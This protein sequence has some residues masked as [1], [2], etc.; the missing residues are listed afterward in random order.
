M[1][2][3]KHAVCQ[4]QIDNTAEVSLDTNDTLAEIPY[5]SLKYIY[6]Q[7]KIVPHRCCSQV[8]RLPAN[9]TFS[10]HITALCIDEA[11]TRV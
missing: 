10:F 4:Q 11:I 3:Q 5:F 9:I 6:L 1:K 7:K 2:K 8:N